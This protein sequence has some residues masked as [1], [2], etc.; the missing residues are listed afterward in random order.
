MRA[1]LHS[2]QHNNLDGLT[3]ISRP[4]TGRHCFD[5]GRENIDHLDFTITFGSRLVRGDESASGGYGS[6]MLI[7]SQHQ[8]Q[9]KRICS[10]L[11]RRICRI[12]AGWNA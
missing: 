7:R 1:T 12:R 10:G 11:R 6:R 8:R 4:N 9:R 5:Y 2:S 3:P